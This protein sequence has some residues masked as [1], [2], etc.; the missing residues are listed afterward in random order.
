M[1]TSALRTGLLCHW[2]SMGVVAGGGTPDG[3]A[4]ML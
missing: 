3:A 2:W 4:V 1:R